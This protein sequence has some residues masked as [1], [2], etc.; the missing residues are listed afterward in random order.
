VDARGCVVW[1]ALVFE[2]VFLLDLIWILDFDFD[3]D[4]DFDLDL[5]LFVFAQRVG[6]LG[7]RSL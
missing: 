2:C 3:F 4:F 6:I 7:L 5:G 1:R